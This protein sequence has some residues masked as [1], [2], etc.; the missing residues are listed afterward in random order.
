MV[1]YDRLLIQ[2]ASVFIRQQ[3]ACF[4]NDAYRSPCYRCRWR[5]LLC[6]CSSLLPADKR[7]TLCMYPVRRADIVPWYH[8]AVDSCVVRSSP[9]ADSTSRQPG[10]EIRV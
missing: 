7:L 9:T 1:L 5:A 10:S 4:S 6:L 3:I 8:E 2:G